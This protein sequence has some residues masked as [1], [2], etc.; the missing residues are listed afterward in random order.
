MDI[1]LDNSTY[2]GLPVIIF[3][4][5]KYAVAVGRERYLKAAKLKVREKLDWV[6]S[7]SSYVPLSEESF[8]FLEKELSTDVFLKV[9]NSLLF[10]G[11]DEWEM[12]FRYVHEKGYRHDSNF[13]LDCE[14]KEG[15]LKWD[16]IREI[17]Y[18][19][20]ERSYVPDV[21][22]DL[23]NLS[24]EEKEKYKHPHGFMSFFRIPHDMMYVY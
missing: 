23:L 17:H 22:M 12:L 9:M 7:L 1:Q 8:D 16:G 3:N 24:S 13:T 19:G 11:S 6:S 20:S 21:L 18:P 15:G 2:Y 14:G 10:E 5:T 4:G